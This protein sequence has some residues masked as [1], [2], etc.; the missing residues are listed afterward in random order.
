MIPIANATHFGPKVLPVVLA[1]GGG[2]VAGYAR[3]L[4]RAFDRPYSQRN[5]EQVEPVQTPNIAS[6]GPE[7][8]S[9]YFT[10]VLEST[11]V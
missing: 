4:P 3:S 6:S 9:K 5:T 2:T 8:R 1:F 10:L 7:A 11:F